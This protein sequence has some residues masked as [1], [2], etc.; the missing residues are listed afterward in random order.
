RFRHPIARTTLDGWSSKIIGRRDVEICVILEEAA[1][2]ETTLRQRSIW[3]KCDLRACRAEFADMESNLED[4]KLV[5]SNCFALFAPEVFEMH[6]FGSIGN[7][8]SSRQETRSLS[9]TERLLA[10]PSLRISICP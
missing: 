6:A 2:G 7:R 4:I 10:K 5:L 9:Q 1:T 8:P 3:R